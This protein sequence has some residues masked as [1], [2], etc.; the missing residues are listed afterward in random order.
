MGWRFARWL[1]FPLLA[2]AAVAASGASLPERSERVV[3]YD[4]AVRL[5]PE[6][7]SITG[8]ERI[9]WRNPSN[10]AVPDLWFHLYLNA[11]RNNESTFFR[12]SGG[13][14]RRDHASDEGWG[15][16][17][18]TAIRLAD[19][20]DL[21]A[22]LDFQRPDDGNENDFTVARVLL[23]KPVRPGGEITVEIEFRATLPE[24]YARSGWAANDFLLVGQ[25]FP[26]LGVYEP[27]GM[28]GRA[29]GGWNCHQYH[30][31]S[32]FYA[33]YGSYRVEITVPSAF[34]VG[35]TGV[36]VE[37]HVGDDG[38]TTHV[39]RQDDVHDFGWTADPSFLEVVETFSGVDDVSLEEYK[40]AAR[41]L[42]RPLEELKLS[43]VEI[44]LLLQ[45]E[46]AAQRERALAA[47]K[48]ALR[49]FGLAWGR[50]PYPTLTV[51]DPPATGDG[52][53]G[54]EYPT[55]VTGGTRWLASHWPFSNLRLPE[56]VIVHEIGHQWWYG[57]AGSNEFEESWLD[58]GFTDYAENLA[59][60]AYGPSA[61]LENP[62][63]A[64]GPQSANRASNSRDRR[65]DAIRTVAWG[66]S[67]RRYGFYSYYKPS[68]VLETLRGLLGDAIFARAMRTYAERFRFRHPSS[69]DFYAVVQEVSGQDLRDLFAQVIEGRGAFDPAVVRA[70]SDE[71]GGFH[72]HPAPVSEH[73]VIAAAT[74]D[75]GEPDGEAAGAAAEQGAKDTDEETDEASEWKSVIDLRHQGEVRLPVTVELRFAEGE[76]ERRTWDGEVPWARWEI[77]G[78]SRLVEVVVD[79]DDVYAIDA[80]RLNNRLSVEADA[81]PAL[82]SSLR[83]LF[84]LQQALAGVGF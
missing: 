78:P 77:V 46:H 17:D 71:V 6:T 64:I 12:E 2:L 83:L 21:S 45:P 47:T 13:S 38:T 31:N 36:R 20:T 59:M 42:D 24:V 53:A 84:W 10:D 48:L 65:Y 22:A 50:Y 80:D 37:E 43:D 82:R 66:F 58:E 26:K 63:V 15:W 27:A 34:V 68:L 69:D 19:G 4:I 1:P 25:W 74:P 79:P 28:R 5:D 55:F 39:Y 14:L 60:A 56:A 11:F 33:D 49:T 23:P 76:P 29:A 7:K 44:H 8:R 41:R 30:A 35:A 51:V 40:E 18:L 61:Y 16:I 9:V 62:F 70:T 57:L 32:E 3:D 54:M 67:P 72:G 75:P 81:K 52:A 73:Y